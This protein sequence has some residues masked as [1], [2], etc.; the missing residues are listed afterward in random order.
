MTVEAI[1]H[2][3][4]RLA[5]MP[6]PGA[7]SSNAR[8][9]LLCLAIALPLGLAGCG[10]NEEGGAEI[11]QES[12]DAMLASVS[13]IRQA[14]AS[15]Q[16]EDAQAATNEL[17]DQVDALPTQTDDEITEALGQMVS[18][19]DEELDAECVETGPTGED[20]EE[21]TTTTEPV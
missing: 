7:A 4:N 11:P 13:T 15:R 9:A 8:R 16:C 3:I 19:L 14:T 12:A 21:T 6:G 20:E 17:R 18:R 10:S 1:R 5:V 2:S